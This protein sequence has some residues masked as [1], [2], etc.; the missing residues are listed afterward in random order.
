MSKLT[1]VLPASEGDAVCGLNALLTQ[2]KVKR[3]LKELGMQ[4]E[5]VDRAA[6]IAAKN[7][8]WNPREVDRD[9]IRELIRR[10]WAGEEARADI[11]IQNK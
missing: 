6:D 5:D 7:P 10:A 9:G 4:E 2:L 11:G 8:Y 1:S 3:G